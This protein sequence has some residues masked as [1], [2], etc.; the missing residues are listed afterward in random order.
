M[1]K[2]IA[3]WGGNGTEEENWNRALPVNGNADENR[4]R[5]LDI[6]DNTQLN[7]RLTSFRALVSDT[8]AGRVTGYSDCYRKMWMVARGA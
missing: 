2:K 4:E 6:R 1:M 5:S 8:N 7:E 3:R